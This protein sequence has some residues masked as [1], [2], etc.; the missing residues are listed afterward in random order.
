MTGPLE[1][2]GDIAAASTALSGLFMVYMGTV[3]AT[4]ETF[5]A[6]SK[7]TVKGKFR[8]RA[9]CGL[10]GLTFALIAALAALAG[11]WLE[12]TALVDISAGAL[13]ASLLVICVSGI[14]VVKDID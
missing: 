9:L 10:A 2:S 14:F 5:D 11:K 13:V 4:Y 3:S 12:A 8:R 6:E 1:V 7:D